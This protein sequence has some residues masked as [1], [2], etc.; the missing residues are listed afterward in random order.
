MK[1]GRGKTLMEEMEVLE[2]YS[3]RLHIESRVERLEKGGR[4]AADGDGFAAVLTVAAILLTTYF[5]I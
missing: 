5:V 4:T 1:P 3:H 2:S